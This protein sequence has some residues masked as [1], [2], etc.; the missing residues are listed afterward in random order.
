MRGNG[1]TPIQLLNENRKAIFHPDQTVTRMFFSELGSYD[2]TDKIK[3]AGMRIFDKIEC[4]LLMVM[5]A[6]MA[7]VVIRPNAQLLG[8]MPLCIE[9]G[10]YVMDVNGDLIDAN[11]S[12]IGA[13]RN[14]ERNQYAGKGGSLQTTFAGDCSNMKII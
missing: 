4:V 13:T 6:I 12:V 10:G 8:F 11:S 14:S 7:H 2:V 5:T 1:A 9:D 3:V